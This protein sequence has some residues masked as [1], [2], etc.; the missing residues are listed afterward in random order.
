MIFPV[1][2]RHEVFSALFDHSLAPLYVKL[3][4]PVSGNSYERF[5]ALMRRFGNLPHQP[6]F[7]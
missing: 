7:P 5:C 3:R 1:V 2:V 4:V 6:Y